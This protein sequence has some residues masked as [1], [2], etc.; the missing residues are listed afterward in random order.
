MNLKPFLPSPVRQ[1]PCLPRFT[2]GWEV[3]F[4]QSKDMTLAQKRH[5]AELQSIIARY[6][7]SDFDTEAMEIDARH[8]NFSPEDAESYRHENIVLSS[9]M[10]GQFSQA[11]RQCSSYGMNYEVELAKFGR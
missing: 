11:K 3:T 10:N 5:Q 4:N 1:F 8:N 6:D 2:G 9:L 7:S